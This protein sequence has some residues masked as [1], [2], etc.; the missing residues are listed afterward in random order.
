MNS[1]ELTE[2]CRLC[3]STHGLL[4]IFDG[5]LS[6]TYNMREVILIT[7]GIEISETDMVSKSICE[8]CFNLTLKMFQFR[9]IAI[10]Q[11][12]V[13]KEKCV[14]LLINGIKVPN[15]CITIKKDRTER[16]ALGRQMKQELMSPPV[17]K[18]EVSSNLKR[19]R[20][21]HSS[22]ADIYKTY[23]HL[24][25]PKKCFADHMAPIVS[26]AM[27]E[28]EQYFRSAKLDMRK[29]IYR[30]RPKVNNIAKKRT[31]VPKQKTVAPLKISKKLLGINDGDNRRNSC[32]D[33]VCSSVDKNKRRRSVSEKKDQ[34]APPNKEKRCSDQV[35]DK[36]IGSEHVD[37]VV[38]T[39]AQVE[40]VV[41]ET[42]LLQPVIPLKSVEQPAAVLS[43]VAVMPS[44]EG[45]HTINRFTTSASTAKPDFI[46]SLGLTPTVTTLKSQTLHIC[47]V[48]GSVHSTI[49]DLK[50]HSR[51]HMVCQFC[52]LKFKTLESKQNHIDQE[53]HMKRI[54]NAGVV[55]K[56]EKIDF[57]RK[58]REKYKG[59][60]MDF[61]PL[62]S[63]EREE[64]EINLKEQTTEEPNK[65]E[66]ALQP[67]EEAPALEQQDKH[68]LVDFIV[69][70]DEETSVQPV[71]H[72]NIATATENFVQ[73]TSVVRP[74]IRIK[75]N[76]LLNFLAPNVADVKLV[77]NLIDLTKS[78]CVESKEKTVQT[79]LPSNKN[80]IIHNSEGTCSFKNLKEQLKVYKVPVSIHNGS[81]SIS[82]MFKPIEIPRRKMASWDQ[83]PVNDVDGIGMIPITAQVSNI[84]LTP[85][86]TNND[87]NIL[88]AVQNPAIPPRQNIVSQ[89]SS[90]LT[91]TVV[92][93]VPSLVPVA[94]STPNQNPAPVIQN[95][96][97]SVIPPF[98]PGQ[99]TIKNST[100]IPSTSVNSNDT[101]NSLSISSNSSLRVNK[102]TSLNTTK[103]HNR[104][105]L[106][107]K[108]PSNCRTAVRT[109][110]RANSV[111]PD[112]NSK[113][114]V[115]NVWELQ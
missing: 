24:K 58:V 74:D 79:D 76:S 25:L 13:L 63:L 11:D 36:V 6:A 100:S 91:N 114:R 70:S 26:L 19:K 112:A 93:I 21:L 2:V 65:P 29:F 45:S 43:G 95:L 4:N 5:G 115:K 73:N 90:F 64:L 105:P 78:Q 12:T 16:K 83:L 47:S 30:P 46:E 42:E 59:A 31:T 50:R 107:F 37:A 49:F 102:N 48:C 87:P 86:T 109:P 20:E 39:Q 110:P 99:E 23:P 84:E 15:T 108:K 57:N 94:A 9:K 88:G 7:T 97:F 80:V 8:N 60:F 18:P 33:Y 32:S 10:K 89:N 81:F 113:F 98:S 96:S 68:P 56:I 40:N 35:I 27:G 3:P 62:P 61:P 104:S 67:L 34:L 1:T 53:C 22:V 14:R 77:K 103:N 69:L 52:K 44:P 66:Q 85:V 38:K 111:I 51:K 75:N 55:V 101:T 82:Y 17:P 106:T 71:T 72:S 54:M 92:H 41:K 28:V